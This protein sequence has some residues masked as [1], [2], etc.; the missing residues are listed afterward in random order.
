MGIA[1]RVSRSVRRK[2][3]LSLEEMLEDERRG[4]WAI[5]LLVLL[6]L[7]AFLLSYDV[8][9]DSW[10]DVFALAAFLVLSVGVGVLVGHLRARLRELVPH[11]AG[12]RLRGGGVG[13]LVLRRDK[14][15]DLAVGAHRR[16]VRCRPLLRDCAKMTEETFVV[17]AAGSS[18][19]HVFNEEGLYAILSEQLKLVQYQHCSWYQIR[20]IEPGVHWD[21]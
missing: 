6:A 1:L 11:R 17:L 8:L 18:Y 12:R 13:G 10:A 20:G 21:S 7:A 14:P 2:R 19:W 9:L 3:G 16:A 5:Y 4:R 15:A